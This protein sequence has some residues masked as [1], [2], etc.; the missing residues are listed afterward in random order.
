M[1]KV[2]MEA[3]IDSA[4][5]VPFLLVIYVGIGFI[6]YK[7]GNRI[8]K[9]VRSAGKAG[10]ALG[11]V[12]GVVPQCGFSVISTALYTKR[13][14]T[15]GT[16]LAVYLSTSDEAIPI[17]MSQPHR[18][19][20]IVPLLTAKITVALLAGYAV[21]FVMGRAAG[22]AAEKEVCASSD[23]ACDNVFSA[24]DPAV[25]EGC[26]GHNCAME[27]PNYKEMV[28]HPIVH[29]LKVFLFVLLISAVINVIIFK[30]GDHNLARLF[31]GHSLL[32]PVITAIVGLIPNCA[33]SVAVTQVFL[34]GGISFGST[35]AGLCANAGLGILVLFRENKNPRDTARVIGLLFGI[36]VIAGMLIQ[37][38][39]G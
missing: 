25:E 30:V 34:K 21:D 18:A 26:C 5:M 19:G 32:Q 16:L 37:T 15:T 17:I 12:F 35:V 38:F 8:R 24:D 4:E 31:L 3:L 14:I 20:V 2:L 22:P 7:F 23:D 28:L 29:T 1:Y 9:K 33:A 36:S 13:L 39:Y 11:A 10:P 27:K 6:E